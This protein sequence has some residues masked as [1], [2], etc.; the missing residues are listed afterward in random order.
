[1]LTA[2]SSNLSRRQWIEQA[3]AEAWQEAQR[4]LKAQQILIPLANFEFRGS[5]QRIQNI[6]D[7]EVIISGPAETGK[8]FAVLSHLHNLAAC[9][10]GMQGVIVRK[11]YKSAVSSVVQS[12]LRKVL[13]AN[14]GVKV[15]GGE[16][17]EWFDY[18]N[19]SRIW[20]GGMDNPDKVLS[21]E[22]DVIYVNQAEELN[23]SD[24][25]T[26]GTRAT[27]RAGNIPF[28]MLIGDCNPGPQTHWIL[29]R[30]NR[31][32]L[33]MLESRHEDNPTLFDA[34]GVITEQGKRTMSIL[35]ALTGVR[36]QR[37]RYG[38]W[39]S[40]E[41]TVYQFDR[42]VHL[43]DRFEIPDNWR[44][45][46]V[47][48]FGYTNP[49]VCGWWAIDHDDRMYL[50]RE[51]YMTQRTVKVHAKQINHL[52][53]GEYI[54]ATIC[55][56]DAEDRATLDE[57]EINTM[58]ASKEVSP[59]IQEVEERLKK[60]GDG[61]PGLFIMRDSLVERDEALADAHK[62]TCTEQEFDTYIWPK[63]K[64]GQPIKEHP[65]KENDHGM[66]MTRYAVRYVDSG[67]QYYWRNL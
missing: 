10:P 42:A 50:Y 2:Y 45:I 27:G 61:R 20:V 51:I 66:D 36:L 31:G 24:W 60:R 13:P 44:R 64:D 4:R 62:P 30:A 46:R 9:H 43:I 41:G 63:S 5:A 3:K 59:G 29:D 47:I 39:V 49:F 28:P 57:N 38:R 67:A 58:S 53:E 54:E 56:T 25:E 19:G 26:L 17:P 34:N 23:L 55:D 35:D 32:R 14:S 15:Y 1:M 52:S 11:T 40:A 48:D 6:K 8:T 65:V 7:H 22:R 18:P 37:L 33:T 16:R 12:Y 21:S